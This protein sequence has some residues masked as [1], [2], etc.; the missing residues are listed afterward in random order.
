METT[1]WIAFSVLESKESFPVLKI[2]SCSVKE[3]SWMYSKMLLRPYI[4]KAKKSW[5]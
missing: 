2:V 1:K 4:D 3:L 5:M